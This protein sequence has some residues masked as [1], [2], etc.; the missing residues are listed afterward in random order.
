MTRI[1]RIVRFAARLSRDIT[2]VALCS[3]LAWA[4]LVAYA[5]PPRESHAPAHADVHSGEVAEGVALTEEEIASDHQVTGAAA[6]SQ[7]DR[8]AV[9]E[10]VA[11]RVEERTDAPVD[12]T[13]LSL[14]GGETRSAVS[15]SAIS[16][17]NA[18]G[19][20][21]GMG[22]S[23]APVLSSGTATFNVPIA[24]AP[25]RAGVQP[26][27][28]LAYSSSGGN[29]SVGFG[30]GIGVPF[31]SRQTDRGLPHYLDRAS[32]HPEEDR[33]IYNGGQELVP[34]DGAAI[35]AVDRQAV[36]GGALGNGPAISVGGPPQDPA[37]VPADVVGWQQY[38]ARVEGGFM[39]FFR[40]PPDA[41]GTVNTWVVQSK[42]GTRFDFGLLP[43]PG[44]SDLDA[45]TSLEIDDEGGT[46]VF[47]WML[48]RMSDA[49]GST[50][51]YRYQR[52]RGQ[53]YVADI[54]YVS[55]AACGG[56][57]DH[58]RT[59]TEALSG[60]GARV[61]FVYESRPDAFTTYTSGY[62]ITTALRLSR[63]EVTA[64]EDS[65]RARTLVRRY[66]L[67]YQTDTF[68]SLLHSVQVEGRPNTSG[69]EAARVQADV[70]DRTI[71]EGALGETDVGP[72]LPP[73]TFGYSSLPTGTGAIAG[74][75]A[76]SGARRVL[77]S[78]PP[79]SID[80]ARSDFFDVNSDGLPDLIVTDPARY[81]TA[82][83]D[84]AVGVFFNGFTGTTA[85][86]GIAGEFSGPVAMPMRG[87]LSGTLTLSNLNIV[88]MDMDG[89]GRTD[90]LHMPRVRSYGWFAATRAADTAA[91]PAIVSP[92][93]QGWRWTYATIDLPSDDLDPRV[94]FGRDSSHL[95]VFDVNADH[96]ADVVRTTGTSIQTWLNLGWVPLRDATGRPAGDGRFGS[97]QYDGTRWVLSTQPITSCLVTAGTPLDFEDPESRLSDMNGDGLVDLVRIRRG[98]VIWWPSRGAGSFG[99]GAHDCASG[100]ADNRYVEMTTPPAEIN[101]D[102][103]GVQ[104]ADVD[105]DGASDVVQVRF[106][107]V[108]VWFN[109]AGQSFTSRF[110]LARTP[111]APDFAP[112]VR[113][114]DIDGSGTVDVVYADGGRWQYVDLLNH[115]QPRMLTSVDNGLGALTSIDYDSSASDYLTDLHTA[116]TSCRDESAGCDRFVWSRVEGGASQ[117]LQ[118]RAPSESSSGMFHAAGTPVI[119]NVVRRIRTSDRFGAY[120]ADQVSE[121]QFAY[122]DGY[123]EGIE[124]EF[125][126]FGAAD[127]AT[128]GDASSPSVYTRTWFHQGRR[129]QDI[130]D[131]RLA[132]SPDEA[133]KG[134]EY[135]TEVFDA[136]GVYLSTAHA[137]LTSRTLLAGLDGRPIQYAFVSQADEV[138]YDTTHYQPLGTALTLPDVV[139]ETAARVPTLDRSRAIRIRGAG[140]VMIRTTYDDVDN[141]GQVRT[142]TA[143]GRVPGVPGSILPANDPPIT[144]HTQP[145]LVNAGSWIWRTQSSAVLGDLVSDGSTGALRTTR[146]DYDP[147]TGD[148]LSSTQEVVAP[149]I[150][151]FGGDLTGEGGA[152]TLTQPA[153]GDTSDDLVASSTFDTWGQAEVS[154]V[155]ANLHASGTTSAQ[156]FRYASVSRAVDTSYRQLVDTETAHVARTG[157]VPT[158]ATSG[159]W[160]RGL[161]VLLTATDPNHLLTRVTYDGLGRLTSVTPP[162]AQG[163]A[164]GV[165]TTRIAYALTTSPAS[166]PVSRVTTSTQLDCH[167]ALGAPGASLTSIGMVD[168]LGRVRATLATAGATEGAFIRSGL[169]RLNTKGAVV[170]AW[171]SDFFASSD[172]PSVL[173]VPGE[174]APHTRSIYDAF[175]RVVVAYAEDDSMTTTSYHA[176]STDVC[177]PLDNDPASMHFRTCTTA[178]TDGHGRLID[179]ILRNRQDSASAVEYHRLWTYYRNDG[180][181]LRL[182]R[183]RT[184]SDGSIRPSTPGGPGDDLYAPPGGGPPPMVTRVFVYDSVGRRIASDD[185][186]TDDRTS[187]NAG[188]RTWRYLFSRAGDLVAVRD[189]RGCGQNFYYDLGGRL[190]GEQYVGCS[191]AQVTSAELPTETIP[192]AVTML[193]S[194]GARTVDVQYFYDDYPEWATLAVVDPP[195]PGSAHL[196]GRATGVADRS[197]RAVV[198]YDDRGNA[199]WTGRQVA[200][201]SAPL[202]LSADLS[203]DFPDVHEASPFVPSTVAYDDTTYVRTALFDHA[204]RPTDMALPRDPDWNW[205]GSADPA[206]LVRGHLSYDPRGLPSHADLI[207]DYPGSGTD[208]TIEVVHAIHYLRDGLV[209]RIEYGHREG[210]AVVRSQTEYDE[211][212]RPTRMSAVRPNP[213][214]TSGLAGVT[215]IADQQL[216]WDAASNLTFIR[217][218]RDPSEWP[219][220]HR[221]QSVEIQHDS[222]YRVV[223]AL[224][225]YSEPGE[226]GS[227][228][229]G[230]DTASDW[231]ES[232]GSGALGGGMGSGPN[233]V[234]PMRP[235]PAPMIT[236]APPERV[237]SLV[238]SWDWLGNMTEWSD[239][240]QQFYERSIGAI[241]N[242]QDVSERPSALY[243]ASSIDPDHP[244][245][246][247]WVELDYGLGG[248]VT[249]VTVHG[250]CAVSTATS[251]GDDPC[252]GASSTVLHQ[253]CELRRS[254]LCSSEQHYQYRW[255]E[256][257][258]ISEA[259]RFDR[260]DG[261][262]AWTIEARQR[263]RYDGA[264]VRVVKQ[265]FD[266]SETAGGLESNDARVGLYVYPGDF[267][268]R[269][270]SVV[271]MSYSAV[272]DSAGTETQYLVAGARTVWDHGPPV[273]VEDG[274][275][276]GR[277]W[278]T[279]L[280][281]GDLLHTTAARV[282]LMSGELIEVSTYYPNGARENLWVPQ[283]GE[284]DGTSV[285]LEPMGFTGKEADEDVGLVYF[286]ERYL[287]ARV[288]RWASPDPVAIHAAAGGEVLN[289][290]H[291]VAGNTLQLRDQIGLD[292]HASSPEIDESY[293][294]FADTGSQEEAG[295]LIGMLDEYYQSHDAMLSRD[296]LEDIVQIRV[297]LA[298][299]HNYPSMQEAFAHREYL[300]A[301]LQGAYA[302]LNTALATFETIGAWG[303]LGESTV[304]SAA[305]WVEALVVGAVLA[306]LGSASRAAS[307]EMGAGG[308]TAGGPQA[309]GRGERC[310]ADSLAS[311]GRARGGTQSATTIW[312]R[313]G[314]RPPEGPH[315]DGMIGRVLN[316]LDQL[317]VRYRSRRSMLADAATGEYRDG[318]YLVMERLATRDPA[319]GQ[320][321]EG[322]HMM[323]VRVRGGTATVFDPDAAEAGF[324]P[325]ED[326]LQ[327]RV[328]T[329][330]WE[331]ID[332]PEDL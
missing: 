149:R 275:E 136:R 300:Q 307:A 230:T 327:N 245:S 316:A 95:L 130:A 273:G 105:G 278:R 196:L 114:M 237:Q 204:G 13:P 281:T 215:A 103:A 185:P 9:A 331:V 315:Y 32:Y 140:A 138:R 182:T 46:H 10:E 308:S 17:P 213:T 22:E 226:S 63:V 23:F 329:H 147:S 42:D 123:Y 302:A 326:S 270:L 189:P 240:A 310:V 297:T 161:G 286:G 49:H 52:D 201:I 205:D 84:P 97:A 62:P 61:H 304:E 191:E 295:E 68:H 116:S 171:Q 65:A 118:Q 79:V 311:A 77:T 47:R 225:D 285:P 330:V 145:V 267:E 167:A 164:D 212:R 236:T 37:D 206:P 35:A 200:L 231:R 156:C 89:D 150:Y 258:R 100:F 31:I 241:T 255:D 177:D 4:P 248:N 276:L 126:G 125:R 279:T 283:T 141:L 314:A 320:V 70:G 259:R 239:D 55:P 229:L 169:T 323:H 20:I 197:Q 232:A 252:D 165:P 179:Q 244:E 291:Y 120:S 7:L 19:S 263:Y 309:G 265:S 11:A 227:T 139:R 332:I 75:G 292:L 91:M 28:S 102:L 176:L 324:A 15:A 117:R 26:S 257:N 209:D 168:G 2:C 154:C 25:G 99:V 94:D 137:T 146:N 104:L 27:L 264:N 243:V 113:L 251:T 254:A 8:G 73:M 256:L 194:T 78:S 172:L 193:P 290:Y 48:T 85:Q 39:R 128:I 92:A 287:I 293:A 210:D 157:P 14:P 88:P 57:P 93:D 98:R 64:Y 175:G 178:R 313:L 238:W 195:L 321:Q 16:L 80:E 106:D 217:D 303:W 110:T 59:C 312:Q 260:G 30:W 208:V 233:G 301:A 203:G 87:D 135:L 170:E 173:S 211:R 107:A 228:S 34:V 268:R 152:E 199:V 74:F 67:A 274:G 69:P 180:A 198:S 296:Y 5:Q 187:S 262:G 319:T 247:G 44:A 294:S 153:V 83:G 81:R 181:V 142:Q 325:I 222:L 132:W 134:R 188:S 298:W 41:H 174:S 249:A 33:F 148:L 56:T 272:I 3:V 6:D 51:Y 269:G 24:V 151:L 111:A 235:D 119:S 1:H 90:L 223:S 166:A 129:P 214:G 131:D 246:S 207:V 271:D 280:A 45:H 82:S 184:G 266:T 21:E 159:T 144:S 277:D 250:Q 36:G 43:G 60:F 124:Q 72:R 38:R 133:L 221:P 317:G 328:I 53:L 29:G 86:P 163:C 96:L 158:L 284:D 299:N 108:D 218:L 322:G 224:F 288:G 219:I 121:T 190:V 202:A 318:D 220:G 40:G 143:L 66:H 54:F 282:D 71:T 216:V 306:G 76:L 261:A 127:S 101:V 253:R 18:E 109:R 115:T 242:G 289:A 186:D 112:R 12:S 183:A 162:A 234:D 50:V 122:H 192:D 155:G 58:A 305:G 160:D